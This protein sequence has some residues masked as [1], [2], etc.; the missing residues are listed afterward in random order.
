VNLTPK[1]GFLVTPLSIHSANFIKLTFVVVS[2]K[3]I[4]G[5]ADLRPSPAALWDN[6]STAPSAPS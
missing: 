3:N 1:I 4:F 6:C 2:H 5:E